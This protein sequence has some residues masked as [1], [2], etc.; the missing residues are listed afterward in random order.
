MATVEEELRYS[1]GED[2]VS[3]NVVA[4]S[5]TSGDDYSESA[6]EELQKR[7]S[8]NI[9]QTLQKKVK[10]FKASHDVKADSDNPNLDRAQYIC[11]SSK[12]KY[13]IGFITVISIT[14]FLCLVMGMVIMYVGITYM[15]GSNDHHCN[16]ITAK[17]DMEITDQK[18]LNVS[19]VNSNYSS[20]DVRK[21]ASINK[22]DITI[23]KSITRTLCSN[24]VK[25]KWRRVAYFDF[26]HDSSTT[27]PENLQLK[28]YPLSCVR[29]TFS[30]GCSSVV[31]ATHDRPYTHV[32]G[33]IVSMQYGRPDGFM[34]F[35]SDVRNA[36]TATLNDNYVDGVSLTHGKKYSRKHIWTF[37]ALN[38][39][40]FYDEQCNKCACKRPK[41]IK[42]RQYTC[43]FVESCSQSTCH[44]T[45]WNNNFVRELPHSTT[46]DIEMR[47]CRDEDRSNEDILLRSVEIYVL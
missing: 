32:C 29:S 25:G 9:Y 20:I 18:L 2:Y 46:D 14:G 6:Y 42:S 36:K 27:C 3:V 31:Y 7:N 45:Y 41:F 23:N 38:V 8:D 26:A 5:E 37:L 15:F 4:Q 28:K 12:F 24:T 1:G 11:S 40:L 33:R 22:S 34:S 13:I 43:S 47:V 16:N 17:F 44:K 30:P 35:S 21:H 39:Y 19:Y 10:Q